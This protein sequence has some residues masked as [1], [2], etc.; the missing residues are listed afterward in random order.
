MI[1]QHADKISNLIEH[2]AAH[3]RV[4]GSARRIRIL[5]LLAEREQTLEEIS[6]ALGKSLAVAARHLRIL[7]YGGMVRSR[8]EG[9]SIY[10]QVDESKTSGCPAVKNRPRDILKKIPFT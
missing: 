9:R 8:R 1:A 3:C 4:C 7:E 5:W 2:Q 6:L 10:Y